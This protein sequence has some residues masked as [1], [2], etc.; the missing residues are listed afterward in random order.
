VHSTHAGRITQPGGPRVVDPCVTGF[1]TSYRNRWT[2]T[3]IWAKIHGEC[4]LPMNAIRTIDPRDSSVGTVTRLETGRQINMG[5][6]SNRRKRVFSSPK[7]PGGLWDPPSLLST[8][9]AS[10]DAWD[11]AAGA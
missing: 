7:H 6:I 2:K 8:A 1:I 3:E 4:N 5:F 11:K 10:S 9:T